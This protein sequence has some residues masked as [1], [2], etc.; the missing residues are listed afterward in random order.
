MNQSDHDAEPEVIADVHC[1][2]ETDLAIFVTIPRGRV[3][4]YVWIPKSVV[5][6]DSE[7]Y[8]AKDNAR[9][10]LVIKHWWAAREGLA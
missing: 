5:H 8:D 6:D 2:S 10:K 3:P 1:V 7:V 9:G 4:Q